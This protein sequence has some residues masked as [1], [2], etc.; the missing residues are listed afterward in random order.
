VPPVNRRA[1][2]SVETRNRI[3]RAAIELIARRGIEDVTVEQITERADVGKGTFFNYFSG[4]EAVL[5]YFGGYQ[6]ENLC[7]ALAN[8]G[9]RGTPRE[10]LVGALRALGEA[11]NLTPELARALWVSCLRE[12]EPE[13]IH[14][15]NIWNMVGILEGLV[16]EAQAAGVVRPDVPA[17]DAARFL[18]GQ[19]FL[20]SLAWCSGF[21]E[22][23][24][25]DLT[26]RYAELA[27]R[28]LAAQ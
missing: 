6:V 9:V 12:P 10:R 27:L 26:E 21:T 3:F 4:K 2:K 19:Y 8:G 11:D 23:T 15:P 14:G 20:A 18:L 13:E 7:A 5:T 17:N 25:P 22:E 24:L 16:R 1:R 28:G